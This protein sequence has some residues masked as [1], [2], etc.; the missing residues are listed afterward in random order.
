MKEAIEYAIDR[1]TSEK[2]WEGIAIVLT[3]VGV[4]L[5]P[6]AAVEI[7]GAG[8]IIYG[9]IRTISNNWSKLFQKD[10]EEPVE[11]A[12]GGE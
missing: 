8:A 1:L 11:E 10:V 2:F 4:I 5:N 3:G 7:A 12:E 9:A 6:E